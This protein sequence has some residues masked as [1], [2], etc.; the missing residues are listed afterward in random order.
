MKLALVRPETSTVPAGGVGLDTWQ[1]WL[2]DAIDRDWRPTEWDAEALLFTGD[3]DNPRTRAYVCRTVSCSTVV[4]TRSFCTKCMEKFK[5]SGLSAEVFAAQYDRRA[6]VTKAGQAPSRCRVER[7][8]AHC[9]YPS[10]AK[11]ICV[12][13]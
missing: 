11:G 6:V 8:D 7:G 12:E 1:R 3:P 10:S 5:A 9:G 13:H 2:E 4:H